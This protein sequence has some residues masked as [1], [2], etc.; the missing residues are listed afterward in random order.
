MYKKIFVKFFILFS[1]IYLNTNY[2]QIFTRVTDNNN[3]IVSNPAPAGYV[4]ISWVDYNNDNWI[5]S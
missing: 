2:A 4:G 1:F 5:Y 3:P